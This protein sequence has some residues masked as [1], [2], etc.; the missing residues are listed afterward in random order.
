MIA[1]V[2]GA[3]GYTGLAVVK[4]LVGRGVEVIAHVRP[5]S[6]RLAEWRELF[7][8]MGASVD[9]TAWEPA[10]MRTTIGAI[11]PDWVFSL[12]GTTRKRARAEGLAGA[13]GYERVDYGLSVLLLDAVVES[14]CA[15]KFVYLSALGAD[16]SRRNAYLDAR[17]RVEERVRASGLPFVIA[18]PSFITGPDRPEHRPA[19]RAAAIVVD[20]V[21]AV[22]AAF[23]GKQVRDRYRSTT[24]DQ[25]AGA[26]VRLAADP[27]KNAAVVQGADLRQQIA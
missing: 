14:G 9:T 6:S 11:R 13:E 27:A 24:A 1:F 22:A 23:G 17:R 3:T 16:S 20:R 26:L 21:L 4:S 15:A 10:A 7:S 8:G 2:A 5:D 19:E 12:L 25:L 18:R